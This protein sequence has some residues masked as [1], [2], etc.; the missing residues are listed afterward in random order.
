MSDDGCASDRLNKWGY[1]YYIFFKLKVTGINK[2]GSLTSSAK[3][4][5]YGR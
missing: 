3:G 1:Y 4:L 2:Q 5:M